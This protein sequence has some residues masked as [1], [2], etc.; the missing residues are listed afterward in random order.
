MD[1]QNLALTGDIID[2][3]VA[4]VAKVIFERNL[5]CSLNLQESKNFLIQLLKSEN[6]VSVESRIEVQW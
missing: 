2:I 4:I 1:S 6:G 5:S 3:T